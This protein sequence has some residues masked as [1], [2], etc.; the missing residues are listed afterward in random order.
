MSI[1]KV[2]KGPAL[3]YDPCKLLFVRMCRKLDL[4]SLELFRKNKKMLQLLMRMF[5]SLIRAV[6]L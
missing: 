2:I 5:H 3:S 4:Q 1:L 6:D